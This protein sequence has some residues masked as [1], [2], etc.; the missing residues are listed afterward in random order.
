MCKIKQKIKL[1]KNL[2]QLILFSVI[3]ILEHHHGHGLYIYK[4]D[5]TLCNKT[6]NME[7]MQPQN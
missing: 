2:N 1:I 5:Y 3:E 4:H 7:S 6:V